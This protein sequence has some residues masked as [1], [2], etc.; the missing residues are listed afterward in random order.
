MAEHFIRERAR[1]NLLVC[2]NCGFDPA[3]RPDLAFLKLRSLFDV[4]HK[5]PLAEGFRYTTTAD[6]LL[7]CPTCHRIEHTQLRMKEEITS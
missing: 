1:S 4:H 6:Y 5:D 2:D 7:L 3:K